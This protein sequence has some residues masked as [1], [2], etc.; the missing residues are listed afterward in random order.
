VDVSDGIDKNDA[1][2]SDDSDDDDDDDDDD[3]GCCDKNYVDG[4]DEDDF[5]DVLII[6][7]D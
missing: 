4:I 6:L 2:I 5:I 3:E 1:D 7:D